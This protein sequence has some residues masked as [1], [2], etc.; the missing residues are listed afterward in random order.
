M[1]IIFIGGTY[2]LFFL[3]FKELVHIGN[4][5]EVMQDVRKLGSLTNF[6]TLNQKLRRKGILQWIPIVNVIE[7]CLYTIYYQTNKNQ[8]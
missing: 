8:Q 3:G 5:Y 6:W 4:T 7:E 1:E 2:Y